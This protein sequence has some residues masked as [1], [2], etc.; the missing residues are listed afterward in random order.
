MMRKQLFSAVTLACLMTV[1]VLPAYGAA[2]EMAPVVEAADV[3][4]V[5]AEGLE[6]AA[7]RAKEILAIDSTIWD[8]FTYDSYDSGSGQRWSLNWRQSADEDQ[9][10]S[11]TI[12]EAG[13]IRS[14]Y[15]YRPLKVSGLAAVRLAQAQQHAD[16]FLA[17]VAVGYADSLHR[18]PEEAVSQSGDSFTF[19]YQQQHD[20]IPVADGTVTIEVNRYTGS[21]TSFYVNESVACGQID[22]PSAGRVI[23]AAAAERALLGEIGVELVYLG[24]YDYGTETYRVY[25]VYRLSK[26]NQVI[27]A[28]TGKAV[29]LTDNPAVAFGKA[30]ANESAAMDSGSAG[31]ARLSPQELAAV[32]A[33]SQL[34]SREAA[35]STLRQAAGVGADYAVRSAALSAGAYEKDRYIWRISLQSGDER[36][37]VSG[38]VDAQTGQ[39]LGF[40]C[41]DEG[42]ALAEPQSEAQAARAVAAFL[43]RY[44]P[45]ELAAS[46]AVETAAAAGEP[47]Y[48]YRYQRLVEGTAFP[49]NGLSVSYDG[50]TGRITSY[51][52][53]WN[54]SVTFPS[55]QEAKQPGEIVR[56]M[57][58]EAQFTLQYAREAEGYRLI[59]DFA[60]QSAM[61]FDPFSGSRLNWQGQAYVPQTLP[62]YRWQGA[63]NENAQRLYENGIYLNEAN[64]AGQRSV[65]QG[66]LAQLLYRS[67]YPYAEASDMAA[68]Y[69]ELNRLGLILQKEAAPNA[70]VPRQQ[71]ALFAVRLL[72]YE[73]LSTFSDLFV[74][75]YSDPAEESYQASVAMAG[76]LGLLTADGSGHIRP[77][78]NLSL[79]EAF[80]LLY[81]ALSK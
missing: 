58:K 76:A 66:E 8:D 14:Y 13:V 27:D 15:Y 49:D 11:V 56:D 37:S 67:R 42:E 38:S 31:G 71:A 12:D 47:Y 63:A 60:D 55:V 46:E 34:V 41:Y 6:A 16:A 57:V 28:M 7:L 59:Y 79:N 21:V 3:E 69:E 20:G 51:Q 75:P 62:V 72:G 43:Q 26:S 10:L 2:L 24:A 40:Y 70:A 30:Y 53:D 18:L 19:V 17:Q 61:R 23:T 65:M 22:W 25:P 54:R 68:V 44:A 5:R 9:R 78:E 33:N 1:Q 50:R 77:T 81:R 73:R 48:T 45:A 4:V 36:Q 52:L 39:L 64:L 80:D 32:E 29:T 74:Y 35:V